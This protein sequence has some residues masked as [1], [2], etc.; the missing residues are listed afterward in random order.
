M[1]ECGKPSHQSEEHPWQ[2]STGL[3]VLFRVVVFGGC[4]GRSGKVDRQLIDRHFLG[5]VINVMDK[6]TRA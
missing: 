3:V 5:N 6:L 2:R 1:N 4:C